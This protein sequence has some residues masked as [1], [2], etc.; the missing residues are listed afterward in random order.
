MGISNQAG[1][2][3]GFHTVQ[4]NGGPV[5]AIGTAALCNGKNTLAQ[6]VTDLVT[7]SRNR[8]A[9]QIGLRECLKYHS[10]MA[11]GVTQPD[12]V[13]HGISLVYLTASGML[14]SS[15]SI[16][17]AVNL[18]LARP[19]GCS[20]GRYLGK[21]A[22][23]VVVI[24]PFILTRPAVGNSPAGQNLTCRRVLIEKHGKRTA[25]PDCDI[26]PNAVIELK[27]FSKAY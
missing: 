13:F 12:Y 9:I 27:Q 1:A 22:F 21:L 5:D 16:P 6:R 26:D 19:D 2:A 4:S 8:F 23:T 11:C 10:T 24:E 14:Q 20:A 15:L 3:G 18:L 25:A 7:D 17:I